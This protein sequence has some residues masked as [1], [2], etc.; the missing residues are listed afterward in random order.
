MTWLP[1]TSAWPVM[2]I[3]EE[4]REFA[5]VAEP[6]A[7]PKSLP[8]FTVAPVERV[9]LGMVRVPATV[10]LTWLKV[11]FELPTGA[12]TLPIV[13]APV[14]RRVPPPRVMVAAS[15]RR[16]ATTTE[17]LSMRSSPPP[18]RSTEVVVGSAPLP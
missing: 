4:T 17:L 2:M 5:S 18:R 6:T 1:V 8:K 3:R 9:R 12:V 11:T 15:L 13:S 14:T 10:S 7:P 16:L